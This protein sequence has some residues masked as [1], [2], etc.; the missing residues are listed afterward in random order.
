MPTRTPEGYI[1]PFV[2]H[3]EIFFDGYKTAIKLRELV[4]HLYNKNFP[5][6][7]SFILNADDRHYSIFL[8]LVNSYKMFG[9][10]DSEFLEVA[11]RIR[12]KYRV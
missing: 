6:D 10:N 2:E 3:E 11:E 9:E 8:E 7:L 4:L 1:S 5:C 12:S